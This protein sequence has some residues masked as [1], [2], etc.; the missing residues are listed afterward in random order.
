MK[1]KKCKYCKSRINLTIDHKIPKIQGGTDD[2]TNLQ[3][4][5]KECNSIKSELSDRQ[6]RRLFK[7]FLRIQDKR[8]LAGAKPYK[9]TYKQYG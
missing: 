4:L 8:V 6:V 1:L 3:C 7:W 2:K 9:I 5:C